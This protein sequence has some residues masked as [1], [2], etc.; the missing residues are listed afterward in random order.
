MLRRLSILILPLALLA[1]SGAD[2]NNS[3]SPAPRENTASPLQQL[4]EQAEPGTLGAA[5]LDLQTGEMRGVNADK[6]MPMQSVFKLP[7][8]IYV[9]HLADQGRLSLDDEVKLT[10]ADLSVSWSPIADKF[11]QKQEYTIE[12][13]IRAAVAQSDNTA[14][15]VLMKR[16]GG[17]EALTRFFQER[18]F[19]DFRVDRYEYELQPQSVGLPVFE[20]QWIGSEAI[21]EA[22]DAVPLEAQK[23][24]M[25]VYLAD[26]RDRMSAETAVKML[27]ALNSGKLL[28]PEMTGKMMEILKSTTTGADRLKAGVPEGATVYHKTGTGTDVDR[29]N[30]ATNDIGIVELADGRKFAI[31][32]FLAGSRQPQEERERLIAEVARL[33][34]TKVAGAAAVP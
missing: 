12:E 14:A 6:P 27:A 34:T 18:G 16:T 17:P 30:S 2:E 20:G 4:A 31:A 24:A 13:L 15:D 32:V 29:V 1:C 3:A 19:D 11:D 8:G 9:M 28:S 25:T 26:P 5:I 10:K 33:A 21:W 22:R 7:L 23:A